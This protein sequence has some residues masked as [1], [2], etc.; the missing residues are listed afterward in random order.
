[1]LI[2]VKV[3]NQGWSHKQKQAFELVIQKIIYRAAKRFNE[4]VKESEKDEHRIHNDRK[5]DLTGEVR[6][7]VSGDPGGAREIADYIMQKDAEEQPGFI[8]VEHLEVN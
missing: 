3:D 7:I 8:G 1:M 5:N 6:I 2:S 4:M